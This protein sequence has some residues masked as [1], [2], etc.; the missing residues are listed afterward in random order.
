MT[1]SKTCTLKDTKN[2]RLFEKVV[3]ET[4]GNL[5]RAK[6]NLTKNRSQT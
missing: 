4:K 2:E 3:D 6:K 1:S 5:G